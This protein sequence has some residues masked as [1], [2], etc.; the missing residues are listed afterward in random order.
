MVVGIFR[1]G[2]VWELPR[3]FGGSGLIYVGRVVWLG[4][5]GTRVPH[6]NVMVIA[7]GCDRKTEH[8]LEAKG[9]I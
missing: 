1:S 7:A 8:G 5:K 2:R 3:F 6:V 9:N 4:L